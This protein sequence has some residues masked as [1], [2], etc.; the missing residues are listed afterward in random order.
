VRVGAEGP[1]LFAGGVAR[2]PAMRRLIQDGYSGP[3]TAAEEPQ[4]IGALGA[5]LHGLS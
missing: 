1:L 5:A 2:N 3:V 4:L